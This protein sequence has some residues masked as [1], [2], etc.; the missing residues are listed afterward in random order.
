MPAGFRVTPGM[1]VTADI[2]VGKRSAKSGPQITKNDSAGLVVGHYS[3]GRNL[4]A[5]QPVGR[6]P[7]IHIGRAM[8][9]A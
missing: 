7:G 9:S 3:S 8:A 6:R 4:I 5:D 1:P 2:K